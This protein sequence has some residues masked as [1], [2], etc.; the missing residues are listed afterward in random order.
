MLT[1]YQLTHDRKTSLS[2]DLI[3][4]GY[5]QDF[6]LSFNIKVPSMGTLTLEI[7]YQSFNHV[8]VVLL[9]VRSPR[10]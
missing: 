1:Y 10:P 4:V 3:S 6:L 8:S 9:V 7:G 5:T 2:T